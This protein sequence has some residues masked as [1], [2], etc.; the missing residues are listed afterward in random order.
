MQGIIIVKCP[1]ATGIVRQYIRNQVGNFLGEYALQSFFAVTPCR[2]VIAFNRA[3]G[4]E[5]S[6]QAFQGKGAVRIHQLK[7]GNFCCAK[8]K[9]Q[10]IVMRALIQGA[11]P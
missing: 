2:F 3:Y 8:P 5:I 9:G 6:D 11:E 1:E 10:A 7:Q 4:M